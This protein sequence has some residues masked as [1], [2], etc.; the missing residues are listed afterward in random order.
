MN[1]MG[2]RIHPWGTPEMTGNKSDKQ[3]L[4]EARWVWSRSIK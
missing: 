4:T 3:L 1:K 2:P